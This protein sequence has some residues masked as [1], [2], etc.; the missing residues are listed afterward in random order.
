MTIKAGAFKLDYSKRTLL[1]AV[2]NLTPDSFSK[3][4]L[5]VKFKTPQARVNHIKALV[6]QGADIID[7]GAESTRPNASLVSSRE[8]I[9]RLIPILK[10]VVPQ[11][12]IPVSV[13]SYKTDVIHAALDQG[14]SIVNNVQGLK[15]SKALLKMVCDYNAALVIM[16]MRGTP[17]S[18]QQ[19]VKYSDLMGNIIT[20]LKASIDFCLDFGLKKDRII[21]DPGIGFAKTAEQNVQIVNQL[22]LLKKLKTPILV[23]TS[24]KSFLGHITGDMN[25]DRLAATAASV[26]LSIVHGANL[27]RVHDVAF[28]KDVI[29]VSDS[30]LYS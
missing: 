29:K 6:A 16:H 15:L 11:I 4:G 12:N 25:K 26:A 18:M 7:I 2:A 30:I 20:D 24:R 8:E 13:D 5:L 17:K 9:S 21:I 10:S 22:N 1:M 3:D 23:G 14:V 19:K 27:V 28:M